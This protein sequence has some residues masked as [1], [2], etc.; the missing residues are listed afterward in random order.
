M[1]PVEPDC[2]GVTT[3]FP[4]LV[5]HPVPFHFMGFH[6][7][8]DQVPDG[9]DMNTD[10]CCFDIYKGEEEEGRGGERRGGKGKG[11]GW[12]GR[13]GYIVNI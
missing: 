12:E 2:D 11:S 13:E 6:H 1:Y 4:D 5:F 7:C 9:T 10:A 8:L 3:E